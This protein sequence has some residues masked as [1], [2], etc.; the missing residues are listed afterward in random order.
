[1]LLVV[2]LIDVF[3]EVSPY[4]GFVILVITLIYGILKIYHMYLSV[5]ELKKKLRA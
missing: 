4:L 1:M 5:K 3:N 2:A